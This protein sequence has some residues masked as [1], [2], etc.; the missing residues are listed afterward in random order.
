V[1]SLVSSVVYSGA[2]EKFY[3]DLKEEGTWIAC[4]WIYI[5]LKQLLR[6][7]SLLGLQLIFWNTTLSYKCNDIQLTVS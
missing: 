7:W 4:S 5:V 3:T 1:L 2:T 6:L